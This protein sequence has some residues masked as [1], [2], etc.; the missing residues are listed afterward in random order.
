M[1]LRNYNVYFN[2]EKIKMIFFII[3]NDESCKA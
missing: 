2:F 1:L 3:Y